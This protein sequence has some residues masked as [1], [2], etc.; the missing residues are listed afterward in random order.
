MALRKNLKGGGDMDTNLGGE[1]SP[2][3]SGSIPSNIFMPTSANVLTF[4]F[5]LH[6]ILGKKLVIW[7]SDNLFFD[8]TSFWAKN[9]HLRGCVKSSPQSRKM[10]KNGQ[11]CQITPPPPLNIDLHPWVGGHNFLIF[12][13]VFFS[14][15]QI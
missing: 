15:E 6:F 12:S 9:R 4:F 13:R 2:Q 11:F 1:A 5:G 8:F 7:E 14:A 10:A 3:Y